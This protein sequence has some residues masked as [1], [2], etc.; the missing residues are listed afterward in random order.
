MFHL[1]GDRKCDANRVCHTNHVC[2]CYANRI[3]NADIFRDRYADIHRRL[4]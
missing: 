4:S 1:Y 2:H 3:S